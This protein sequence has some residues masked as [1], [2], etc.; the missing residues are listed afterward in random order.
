M[1]T[2]SRMTAGGRG[3]APSAGWVTTA[4]D[5][6]SCWKSGWSVLGAGSSGPAGKLVSASVAIAGVPNRLATTVNANA[7]LTELIIAGLTNDA[8]FSSARGV[9][10]CRPSG[11]GV[12]KSF[13]GGLRAAAFPGPLELPPKR[14]QSGKKHQQSDGSSRCRFLVPPPFKSASLLE[15]G[16][17]LLN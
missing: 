2:S 16:S 6:S 9:Q 13:T 14:C 10:F 11:P 17:L 12:I 1:I 5:W 8:D 7:L 3:S 4:P 15:K